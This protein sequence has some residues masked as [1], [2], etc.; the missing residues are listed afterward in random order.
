MGVWKRQGGD[1]SQVEKLYF[2]VK[3]I[4]MKDLP[5]DLVLF[6]IR[7]E[8]YHIACKYIE[9][10]IYVVYS[11]HNDILSPKVKYESMRDQL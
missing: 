3:K 10:Q 8:K 7:H 6:I 9:T 5:I 11:S 2:Q 4:S 1:N